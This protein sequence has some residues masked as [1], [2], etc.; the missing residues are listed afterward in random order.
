MKRMPLVSARGSFFVRHHP[1]VIVGVDAEPE[2][3]SEFVGYTAV[4]VKPLSVIIARLG[5]G[6][7]EGVERVLK[8]SGVPASALVGVVEISD[9][10]FEGDTFHTA[11]AIGVDVKSGPVT[12]CVNVV[13]VAVCQVIT[14]VYRCQ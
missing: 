1:H 9:T 13:I 2:C 6:K 4:D 3:R 11:Y 8:Q 12:R 5:V 10:A 7:D 14:S